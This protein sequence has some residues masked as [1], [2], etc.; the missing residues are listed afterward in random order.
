MTLLP[1]FISTARD[2]D[3]GRWR[4]M[5]SLANVVAGLFA[6]IAALLFGSKNCSQ[7]GR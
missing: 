5:S 4:A 6:V 1:K 7:Q 3:P 2:M